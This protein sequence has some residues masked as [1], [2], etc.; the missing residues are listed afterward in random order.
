MDAL[1]GHDLEQLAQV[2]V[3]ALRQE[4]P[5]VGKTPGPHSIVPA[6]GR[7]GGGNQ[8][9]DLKA[10][11]VQDPTQKDSERMKQTGGSLE[12]IYIY[13]RFANAAPESKLC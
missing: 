9:P 10:K 3:G 7:D 6:G 8:N 1:M 12:A 2:L 4:Q 11:G 13:E 5:G